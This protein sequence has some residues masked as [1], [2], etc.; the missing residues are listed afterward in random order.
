MPLV[1]R[2]LTT[3]AIVLVALPAA[4]TAHLRTIAPPG[5]PAVSQYLE[6][7]P[8]DKG[9]SPTSSTGQQGGALT[10]SQRQSLGRAGGD[11]RTL[12][13]VVQATSPPPAAAGRGQGG[14]RVATGPGAAGDLPSA[15]LSGQGARTPAASILAAAG[16]SGGMGIL[17]PALMTAVVLGLIARIAIQWRRSRLS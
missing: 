13:A 5:N 4:A 6:T 10:P 1:A 9:Q 16:G 2:I 3:L 12:V 17:L 7:V 8:T 15:A 14:D 11:G